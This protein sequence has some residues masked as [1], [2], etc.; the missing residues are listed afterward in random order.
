L[1]VLLDADQPRPGRGQDADRSSDQGEIV[2]E[3]RDRIAYLERPV[4]EERDARRR[5]D[6][7]LARLMDRVPELEPPAQQP[8]PPESRQEDAQGAARAG[9]GGTE[10]PAA[11][12]RV[13]W[14][15]RVFGG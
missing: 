12:E 1:F 4:E 6:T 10:P 15:R 14:W 11:S 7:L 3:L 2:V 9:L 5:A 8:A 13:S